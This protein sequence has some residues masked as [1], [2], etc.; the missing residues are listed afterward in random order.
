M[1]APSFTLVSHAWSGRTTLVKS[2]SVAR[3]IVL[4]MISTATSPSPSLSRS[5]EIS[6]RL[7]FHSLVVSRGTVNKTVGWL[8][9]GSLLVPLRKHSRDNQPSKPRRSQILREMSSH[10]L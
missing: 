6:S 10:L 2:T 9:W 1:L 4:R 3:Q 8:S 5:I 7:L